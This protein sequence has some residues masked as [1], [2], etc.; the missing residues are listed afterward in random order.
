M[1]FALSVMRS[2]GLD[3]YVLLTFRVKYNAEGSD[4]VTMPTLPYPFRPYTRGSGQQGHMLRGAVF[5]T[6]ET[7]TRIVT[8]VPVNMRCESMRGARR[9]RT[10]DRDGRKAPSR[11]KLCDGIR[12]SGSIFEVH[13]VQ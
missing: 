8:P 4:H 5:F 2:Y 6:L 9:R 11:V 1:Q 10:Q 3:I 7:L 13:S 12:T